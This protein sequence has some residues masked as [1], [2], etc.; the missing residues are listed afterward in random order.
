MFKGNSL[1]VQWLGLSPF[2]DK[3]PGSIPGRRTKDPTS[4][5]ARPKKKIKVQK[6][7]DVDHLIPLKLHICIH[8]L[9]A[10]FGKFSS[11]LVL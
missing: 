4:L 1:T 7:L 2:A 11:H 3:G 10:L 6:S 5:E 9:L 8:P